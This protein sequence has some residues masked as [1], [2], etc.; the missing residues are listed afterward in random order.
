MRASDRH[1]LRERSEFIVALLFRCGFFLSRF[2]STNTIAAYLRSSFFMPLSDVW[3]TATTRESSAKDFFLNILRF[4]LRTLCCVHWKK[5]SSDCE[6]AQ[7]KWNEY[8]IKNK[9][10]Y[11]IDKKERI[12]NLF[13]RFLPSPARVDA[14]LRHF[15]SPLAC[16][17]RKIKCLWQQ[18]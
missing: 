13:S 4:E 12:V 15:L 16:G 1:V 11:T 9:W 8:K 2:Y 6:P 3:M 17:A 5:R 14:L 18:I 10:I 7:W